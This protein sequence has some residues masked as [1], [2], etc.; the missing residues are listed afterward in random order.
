[1]CAKVK[2]AKAGARRE[3]TLQ[4]LVHAVQRRLDT[5]GRVPAPDQYG[6]ITFDVDGQ[7]THSYE[8]NTT[9]QHVTVRRSNG[10]CP[11]SFADS[12]RV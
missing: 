7:P 11:G 1:V 4:H 2:W 10:A 12:C 9:V 8:W 5:Q 6:Y 3:F